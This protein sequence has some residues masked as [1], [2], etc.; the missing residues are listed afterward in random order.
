MINKLQFIDLEGLGKEEGSGGDTWISLGRENNSCC[1]WTGSGG[2]RNGR[3]HVW[4]E[5]GWRVRVQGEMAGIGGIWIVV[6]KPSTVE[7]S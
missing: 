6:W 1:G 7:T 5:M 4:G 2:N 3:D